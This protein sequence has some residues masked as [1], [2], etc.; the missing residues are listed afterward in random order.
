M[1][2]H[3]DVTHQLG[4]WWMAQQWRDRYHGECWVFTGFSFSAIH[5]GAYN[6]MKGTQKV[7]GQFR[8]DL[9]NAFHVYGIEWTAEEITFLMDGVKFHSFKNERSG[10][11]VWPFDQEFHLLL[12]IAVGGNWG[13]KQG[14]DDKLFPQQLLVDYV[15]VYQ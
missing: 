4:L 7:N 13:G 5:T 10:T 12:N 11:Q 6:G 3:L 9:Y 1:A 15:R 14:V 8:K 2:R